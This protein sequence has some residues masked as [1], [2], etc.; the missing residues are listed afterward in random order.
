[1]TLHTQNSLLRHCLDSLYLCLSICWSHLGTRIGC[2]FLWRQSS[3]V[4]I[5]MKRSPCLSGHLCSSEFSWLSSSNNSNRLSV[6]LTWQVPTKT[7]RCWWIGVIRI[8]AKLC[9]D[10]SLLLTFYFSTAAFKLKDW[11]NQFF[12]FLQLYISHNNVAFFALPVGQNANF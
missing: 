9:S 7:T 10:L 3:C 11:N 2:V 5:W 1:M 12:T 8:S 6:L 4:I